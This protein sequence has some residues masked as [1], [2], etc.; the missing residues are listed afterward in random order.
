MLKYL[1]DTIDMRGKAV[2]KFNRVQNA[3]RNILYGIIQRIYQLI[4]PFVMRTAMIYCLGVEYLGLDGLFISILSVLNLAELGV[5]SAMVY[6][7]YKPI[8]ED[9]KATI[10]AL[11]K[12]YKVYYRIIGC[13]VLVSGLVVCPFLPK[14]ITGNIPEGLNIYI[15]YIL[16]LGS[17]VLSYWLFA[18]KNSLLQAYQRADVVSKLT[19]I[20]NTFRYLLQFIVLCVFR[21]YYLFL[22]IALAS[23]VGIN[24][25]TALVVDN[26]YPGYDAKGEIAC[27]E[28]KRINERIRDLFTAKIGAVVVNSVDT[29]VISAFLGLTVLAIYQNYYYIITALL[30][31][32][33]IIIYSCTATI[34]NSIIVETK[35]KNYC[36]LK[37]FTFLISCIAMFCTSCLVCI[38]Q[39]F[40]ELWVGEKLMFEFSAVICFAIYFFIVQINTLLNTYKDAAGI[41]HED[42][43]RPL[44][45]AF[46]NLIMNLIFVQFWG[47]YGVLF[48]T[49][50]SMLFIGMPWLLHN[51][52][53]TVFDKKNL[54]EFSIKLLEYSAVAIFITIVSWKIGQTVELN[55]I[56]LIVIRLMIC[57][58][59]FCFI[60]I[61]VFH[62][63]DEF[64]RMVNLGKTVLKYKFR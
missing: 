55:G 24:I 39:P 59:V 28:R 34:G 64:K 29:L 12:L 30:S 31:I 18:Y 60:S 20:V 27:S 3:S 26:M 2:M 8:V 56:L 50:F 45:T 7:M 13:I 43:F 4:I 6:S 10:G 58:V 57:T 44:I 41:W 47:I 9:D 17:T 63:S 21:D 54:L 48:S 5:G 23:Q 37:T 51:L 35:E 19:M 16:N 53:T 62:K 14:L 52:F 15:L 49:V 40:M 25:L 61:L 46:A 22:I 11:M 38:F 1:C 32:I 36:D 42:R 33:N